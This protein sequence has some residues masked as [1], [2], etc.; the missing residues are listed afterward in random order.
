MQH[1][2]ELALSSLTIALAIIAIAIFIYYGVGTMFY[3]A[4]LLAI[5]VGFV[6]AWL[7]SKTGEAPAPSAAA[8][9]YP[10]RRKR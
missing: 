6:N 9:Q 8:K 4:V 10:A 2:L 5:A 7:I 3:V 1:T